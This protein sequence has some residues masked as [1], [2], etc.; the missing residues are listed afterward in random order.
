LYTSATVAKPSLSSETSAGII[1]ADDAGA[2]E[3]VTSGNV[4]EESATSDDIAEEDLVR[5]CPEPCEEEAG[6]AS[7]DGIIAAE[8]PSGKSCA[9]DPPNESQE[10]EF[11]P[12]EHDSIFEDSDE[13]GSPVESPGCTPE[14]VSASP[15]AASTAASAKGAATA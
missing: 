5:E 2:S 6:T 15:H 12:D 11:R 1:A 10:L 3:E 9:D 4:A 13:A 14:A 8:D 7:D